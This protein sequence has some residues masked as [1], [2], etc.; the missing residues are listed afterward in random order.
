[1]VNCES[2]QRTKVGAP[3]LR[4][5]R[6]G[7]RRHLLLARGPARLGC[8]GIPWLLDGLFRRA[9]GPA[10]R[11]ASRAGDRLL[12]QLLPDR[13]AKA[14]PA[15]WDFASPAA[16]LQ[17]RQ[18]SAVAA[19]RRYGVVDDQGVR[20]AA[21]LAA[22]AAR[23]APFDGR[24]LFAANLAAAVAGGTARQTVACG[25][26]AAGTPWRRACSRLGVI[27]YHRPR[28]QR[29]ARRGGPGAA[30][31]DHAQSRL[32][33]R[34]VEPLP[35]SAGAAR[36]AMDGDGC[37][38][39]TPDATSNS[40]SRTP[41]TCLRCRHL[42]GWPTTTWRHCFAHSPRSPGWWSPR[43]CPLRDSDGAGPRRP[44]GRQ[45]ALVLGR[46]PR[47]VKPPRA[48]ANAGPPRLSRRGLG[49]PPACGG[50]RSR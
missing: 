14:L 47:T 12:L 31:D 37:T 22:K 42:M 40:A 39:P 23:S 13:V 19:L 3:L 4:P 36:D 30:A 17:A 33:R 29:A 45:R 49:A 5:P 6:A 8:A 35:G 1:M 26:V 44:R 28:V 41:P 9:F 50:A 38:Q 46:R 16:A 48:C 20:T 25:H 18:E 7:A 32:R 34:A 24:P 15:A 21:E 43:R 10:G 11:R 2:G 27:G